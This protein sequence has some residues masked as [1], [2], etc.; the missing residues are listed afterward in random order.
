MAFDLNYDN[1]VSMDWTIL[2]H[3][4]TD[5]TYSPYPYQNIQRPVIIWSMG[6]DGKA[7]KSRSNGYNKDNIKNWE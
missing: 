6:P 7:A 4:N 5:P 3:S 2:R 1:K